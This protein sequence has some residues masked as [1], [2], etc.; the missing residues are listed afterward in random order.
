MKNTFRNL[1]ASS[2]LATSYAS[3][4]QQVVFDEHAHQSVKPK[5]VAIIGMNTPILSDSTL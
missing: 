1:V 4:E 2:L 3:Q 5:Q